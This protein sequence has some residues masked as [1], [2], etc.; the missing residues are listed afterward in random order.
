M[1]E[2]AGPGG[3]KLPPMAARSRDA[4]GPAGDRSS[5]TASLGDSL[6]ACALFIS[7]T[8]AYLAAGYAGLAVVEWVWIRIFG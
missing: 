1:N 7:Y 4:L 2:P 6:R 5:R 3:G 8:A